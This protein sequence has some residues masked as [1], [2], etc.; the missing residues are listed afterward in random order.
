MA[1][2]RKRP[3]DR[4]A[5]DEGAVGPGV[6]GM[7]RLDGYAKDREAAGSNAPAAILAP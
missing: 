7:D 1:Q 4:R 5:V 6:A 2:R 3:V